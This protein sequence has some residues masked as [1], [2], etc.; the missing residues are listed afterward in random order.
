M[1]PRFKLGKIAEEDLHMPCPF[2]DYKEFNQLGIS[3]PS[4]TAQPLDRNGP[5][6]LRPE[7]LQDICV[8]RPV[9]IEM[10]LRTVRRHAMK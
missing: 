4:E 5:T 10:P 2:Q 1:R 9:G 8:D 7:S 3:N 6:E